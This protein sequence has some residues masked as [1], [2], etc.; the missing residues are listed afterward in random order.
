M[1][2]LQDFVFTIESE[3]FTVLGALRGVV[4]EVSAV[5]SHVAH[6]QTVYEQRELDPLSP[7]LIAQNS[8]LQRSFSDLVSTMLELDVEISNTLSL[9]GVSLDLIRTKIINAKKSFQ[10]RPDFERLMKAVDKLIVELDNICNSLEATL[11][12]IFE[13]IYCLEEWV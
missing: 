2:Q 13:A 3:I 9:A 11:K 7:N 8:D 12:R 4:Q 5:Y 6:V 10:T 1:H